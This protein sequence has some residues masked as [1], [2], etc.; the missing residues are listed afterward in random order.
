MEAA[1]KGVA[2]AISGTLVQLEQAKG[3]PSAI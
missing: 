1:Q 3:D 2:P